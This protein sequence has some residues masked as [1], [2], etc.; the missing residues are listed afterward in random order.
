[1]LNLKYIKNQVNLP[2]ISLKTGFSYKNNLKNQPLITKN[3]I[4]TKK[5]LIFSVKMGNGAA[6]FL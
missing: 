6:N 3:T 2:L 1:M 4:K 5:L